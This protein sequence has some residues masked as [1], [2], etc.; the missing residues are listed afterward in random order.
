MTGKDHAAFVVPTKDNTHDQ[1]H[2]TKMTN[3]AAS[4]S[5]IGPTQI[6]ETF[7]A[8][9]APGL[10]AGAE[11]ST[12]GKDPQ[13]ELQQRL[14]TKYQYPPLADDSDHIRILDLFPGERDDPIRARLEPSSLSNRPSYEAISYAWGSKTDTDAV[15][16]CEGGLEYSVEIPKSLHG[17]LQQLRHHCDHR[18]IWADA[19][20]MNQTDDE[21][22]NHQ[23]RLMR[24]IYQRATVVVI[25]LGHGDDIPYKVDSLFDIISHI[26]QHNQI[27]SPEEREIW[28]ALG[29]LFQRSWFERVWCLQEAVLAPSAKVM[30]GEHTTFW[31]RVGLAARTIHYNSSHFPSG[32]GLKDGVRNAYLMYWLSHVHERRVVPSVLVLLQLTR[33]FMASDC[34]DK[35]YGIL[36]IPTT[37]SDPDAG[38]PFLQPDYTKTPSE[39]YIDC[40]SA[41]IQRTQSLRLLSLVQ[42]WN[43]RGRTADILKRI[44]ADATIV[45]VPSWVPRWHQHSTRIIGPYHEATNNFDASASLSL[46]PGLKTEVRGSE[47]VTYGARMT[48]VGS[49]SRTFDSSMT[50]PH[51]AP[52]VAAE[53]W[54][55]ASDHLRASTTDPTEAL[56]ALSTLLTAG[57]DWYGRIVQ[58]REQHFA[59]FQDFIRTAAVLSHGELAADVPPGD[60]AQGAMSSPQAPP[61]SRGDDPQPPP[62]PPPPPGRRANALVDALFRPRTDIAVPAEPPRPRAGKASRFQAALRIVCTWRRLVVT[63]DGHVGLGPEAAEPGDVVC[64]LGDSRVPLLL[65]PDAAG[66][67]GG[68][69]RLVGEAYI[70]GMMFGEA[71]IPEVE[72]IV[73]SDRPFVT[74]EEVVGLRDEA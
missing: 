36:G 7:R 41:I 19:V 44:E 51:N 9:E 69:F 20:C 17:A 43:L 22:K 61:G 27:P 13:Q 62:P 49:V 16:I 18:S 59:D 64:I 68:R 65:R 60:Q 3:G 52:Q 70:Q 46:D 32:E 63:E 40:A 55:G 38:E 34:R 2:S 31:E 30:L 35:I 23:V 66:A 45:N 47:L 72:Q 10:E 24:K 37:D 58:D 48:A 39:V 53:I 57:Q 14:T 21:E 71:G 12:A 56:Y 73:L 28:T 6:P 74:V 15:L 26:G 8:A 11:A 25:W 4:D 5:T 50:L 42:H 67:G 33:R 29:R 1:S 54:A